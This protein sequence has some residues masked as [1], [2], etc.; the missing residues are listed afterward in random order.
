MWALLIGVLATGGLVKY[1]WG[2]KEEP[3]LKPALRKAKLIRL[4]KKTEGKL[5]LDEAEDG[6]VLAREFNSPGL[7][8]RFKVVVTR[9][10]AK[11]TKGKIQ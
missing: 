6:A 1:A 4:G 10:K 2:Q 3:T 5:S 8:K 7:E 9:L 11:R